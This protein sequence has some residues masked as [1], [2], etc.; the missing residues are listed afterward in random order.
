MFAAPGENGGPGSSVSW[1]ARGQP[2]GSATTAD[3]ARCRLVDQS[4]PNDRV[5]SRLSLKSFAVVPNLLRAASFGKDRRWVD[6]DCA[7]R[8]QRRSG[9]SSQRAG[10][11]LRR[12]RWTV[13]YA[14]RATGR[15]TPVPM[16]GMI[17]GGG[18]RRGVREREWPSLVLSHFD[19]SSWDEHYVSR[20]KVGVAKI[21]SR[22]TH[23][24]EVREV[25]ERWVE[26]IA[27]LTT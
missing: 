20:A 4:A 18:S 2:F 11:E 6:R 13:L 9:W 25:L 7:P 16:V 17:G 8:S 22:G 27:K 12:R 15:A 23:H 5:T 24:A 10:A 19:C 21:Y 26:R 1:A 3:T 14:S